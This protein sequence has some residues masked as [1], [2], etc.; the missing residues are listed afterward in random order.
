MLEVYVVFTLLF[1]IFHLG[2]ELYEKC[3]LSSLESLDKRLK[4]A[5]NILAIVWMLATIVIV[6]YG[7]TVT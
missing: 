7:I 4:L 3:S 6:V 1:A 5:D 2:L